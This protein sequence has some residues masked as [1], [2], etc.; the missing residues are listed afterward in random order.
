M[1]GDRRRR[2]VNA[3][4]G[5][6]AP[7]VVGDGVQDIRLVAGSLGVPDRVDAPARIDRD[8][9]ATV[10]ARGDP[11]VVD[12]DALRGAH[13]PSAIARAR[14]D[15]VADVAG[16]HLAPEDRER[17]GLGGS[18]RDATA[19]AGLVIV[20]LHDGLDAA[21]AI[22]H[23]REI[24]VRPFA[25]WRLD[26]R[27]DHG[28]VRSDRHVLERVRGG[29]WGRLLVHAER[30]LERLAPVERARQLQV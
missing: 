4:W 3:T 26:P 29:V 10:R 20:E 30:R 15:H 8:A 23:A 13:R 7:A 22:D 27:D 2:D 11:P 6:E 17:V 9:A 5:A 21:A 19:H 18:E 16:K 12:A 1:I 28:P 14:E 24:G 25:L